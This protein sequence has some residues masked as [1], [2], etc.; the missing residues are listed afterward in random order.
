MRL[1]GKLRV[2]KSWRTGKEEGSWWPT[3]REEA[4]REDIAFYW[5]YGDPPCPVPTHTA[6]TSKVFTVTGERVCCA[7]DA[8]TAAFQAAKAAGEPVG[9]GEAATAAGYYWTETPAKYCGHVGKMTLTGKCW[10]CT[11]ERINSPRQLA[12]KAGEAWYQPADGDT[13]P[14]GHLAPRR[15]S[16]GAC[17]QCEDEARPSTARV[18]PADAVPIHKQHPDMILSRADA[19]GF[20]FT[21]YRTGKPCKNGHTGWRYLSTG[22]CLTCMGR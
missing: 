6:G 3:T 10:T 18:A 17:R 8:A 13:C 7:T 5:P 19:E 14:R 22:A 1:K 16:N 15:V 4:F 21:V 20:G 9:P 11:Q 12:V 2:V